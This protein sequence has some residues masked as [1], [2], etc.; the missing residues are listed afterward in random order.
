MWVLY[1]FIISVMVYLVYVYEEMA[2]TAF[3]V[4]P[5]LLCLLMFLISLLK[6][7]FD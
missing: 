4:L 1:L 5:I 7:M 6:K 3:F 2:L